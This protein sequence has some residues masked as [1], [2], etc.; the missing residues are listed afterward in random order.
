MSALGMISTQDV[1]PRE[2]FGLWQNGLL[3]LCSKLGTE[4]QAD[5]SF[6]GK[7]EYAMI[8]D[9]RVAKL[10]ASRHRVIRRP[11]FVRRDE[12]DFL[13][14]VLQIRGPSCFEQGGREVNLG[15]G[16]WCVY[17]ATQPYSVRVPQDTET[18]LAMV[19]RKNITTE[20]IH[21]EDLLV[22]K[23]SSRAG[24]GKLAVQFLVSA[25]DEIPI[26]TPEAEWEI[27][28]AITNLVRLTMLDASE[29]QTEISLRH[30]WRDRIKSYIV[31]HLRDPELSIDQIAVALNCTKRYLHKV[32][33]PETT[34]VSEW[35]LR[36]R[37]TRC[38]ED[39]C[40]PA[41]ARASITDIAYSWGFNNAAHFSRAF[42]EEF[43]VPPSVFRTGERMDGRVIQFSA[44]RRLGA[45][46][47]PSKLKQSDI[48]SYS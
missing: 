13:K 3:Q 22:R 29:I 7:I 32:F 48:S 4:I 45:G 46:A 10:K 31:S 15:P 2:K 17:D 14:V 34:S 23:F 42:K 44:M 20:R 25:F 35:I 33:Q 47:K 12:G 9:V 6:W 18:L 38:R 1:P 24:M 28:G 43:H 37:L 26:I 16:E 8:G 5:R 30:V 21:V 27:A 36:M 11:L 41:R 39:L 19:P 40:N